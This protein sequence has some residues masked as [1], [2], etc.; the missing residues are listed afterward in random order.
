M[1]QPAIQLTPEP[2]TANCPGLSPEQL[3]VI[4]N[5]CE[6]RKV[7][8]LTLLDYSPNHYDF[9]V[10]FRPEGVE[11]WHAEYPFLAEDLE[12]GLPAC[13]VGLLTPYLYQ[14]RRDYYQ[15]SNSLPHTVYQYA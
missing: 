4:R 6:D 14:E 3:T 11:A 1:T 15:K 12:N 9:L 7:L 8:F 13:C 10:E 2:T 5:I